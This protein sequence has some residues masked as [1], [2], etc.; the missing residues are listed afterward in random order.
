MDENM[1]QGEGRSKIQNTPKGGSRRENPLY[2]AL[3][4][5]IEA[6]AVDS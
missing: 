2:I 4:P 6:K 3:Y 5:P 1:Y